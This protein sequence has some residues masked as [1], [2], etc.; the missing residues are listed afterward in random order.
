MC[1]NIP[2]SLE[3]VQP[4]VPQFQAPACSPPPTAGQLELSLFLPAPGKTG[5]SNSSLRFKGQEAEKTRFLSI[6]GVGVGTVAEDKPC[7]LE[8]Q[9]SPPLEEAKLG[10]RCA[11]PTPNTEHEVYASAC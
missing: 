1:L 11:N 7:F 3:R 10:C 4:E 6:C 2:E 9:M 5:T 8:P